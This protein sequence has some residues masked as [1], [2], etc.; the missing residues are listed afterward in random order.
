MIAF[1]NSAKKGEMDAVLTQLANRLI[2]NGA[3]PAGIVQI[4]S[5]RDCDHRCDMDVRVLPDGP[6]LRISQSLGKESR[7]CRLDIDA[8]EASVVEVK[9]TLDGTVDVFILNKFGKMEAE[10]RGFRDIIAQAVMLGIPVICAVNP[11]NEKAFE[12]FSSGSAV[13]VE[14]SLDALLAWCESEGA[15]RRANV[16]AV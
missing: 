9:K 15:L 6:V 2:E 10:G 8:L 1:T 3:R 13:K 14:S 7:G 12:D 5:D 4:N 11:Q 16:S